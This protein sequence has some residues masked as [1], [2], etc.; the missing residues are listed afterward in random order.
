MALA[1]LAFFA[2]ANALQPAGSYQ[3]Y[4]RA[5]HEKSLRTKATL[6]LFQRDFSDLG[7][8]SQGFVQSA[9]NALEMRV[10]EYLAFV[11]F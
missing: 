9:Y 8:H 3:K 7:F 4:F 10:V 1:R 2:S 6:T 5:N 11:R